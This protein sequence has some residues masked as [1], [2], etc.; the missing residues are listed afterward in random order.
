MCI[1]ARN[2]IDSFKAGEIVRPLEF[3]RNFTPEMTERD[4]ARRMCFFHEI[5]E[6]EL[7]RFNA[8]EFY[9]PLSSK[10][11][12][13]KKVNKE[14]DDF[15]GDDRY[16]AYY[17]DCWIEYVP[18]GCF[19]SEDDIWSFIPGPK[20]AFSTIRKY[21]NNAANEGKLFKYNTIQGR[22]YFKGSK[23]VK[24]DYNEIQKLF[25][26]FLKKKKIFDKF[27]ENVRKTSRFEDLEDPVRYILANDR[28]PLSPTS[29]ISL[30]FVWREVPEGFEFWKK[31]YD[32]WCIALIKHFR[33]EVGTNLER[34]I[35]SDV[36][37]KSYFTS[38]LEDVAKDL[39]LSEGWNLTKCTTL[40]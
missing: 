25:I 39:L 12:F 35:N 3:A 4:K 10:T 2:F 13:I 18:D 31:I 14:Y 6:R 16:Y 9:K 7:L 33:P 37:L 32:D 21:L 26:D 38:N 15:R 34:L 28:Q 1:S 36:T 29:W 27:R 40:V 20:P 24:K 5:A 30:A 11:E 22:Y 8:F 19:F 23:I 17:V